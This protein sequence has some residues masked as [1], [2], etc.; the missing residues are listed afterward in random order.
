MLKFKIDFEIDE[1]RL[2]EMFENRE[3]KFSKNKIK[4]LKS[5][6]N[7]NFS[8]WFDELNEEF[9]RIV[10]DWIENYFND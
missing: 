8:D 5:Q 7:E 3:V 6:M 2:M 9:E 1:E 10:D 4:V